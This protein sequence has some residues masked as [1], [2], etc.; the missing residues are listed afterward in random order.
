ML[1]TILV[2]HVPV[3]G[4]SKER[5]RYQPMD[6]SGDI[7]ACYARTDDEVAGS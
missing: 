3:M 4:F 6:T 7:P 1:V 5:R 2:V